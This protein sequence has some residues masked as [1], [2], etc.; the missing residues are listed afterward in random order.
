VRVFFFFFFFC[1]TC[2]EGITLEVDVCGIVMYLQHF[3]MPLYDIS[4][5]LNLYV[6]PHNIIM[7]QC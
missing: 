4:G 6:V 2:S 3:D 1:A 7:F 5:M